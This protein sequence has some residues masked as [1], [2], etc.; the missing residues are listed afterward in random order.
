MKGNW[1]DQALAEERKIVPINLE[2]RTAWKRSERPI[3]WDEALLY[4]DLR[5]LNTCIISA[6]GGGVHAGTIGQHDLQARLPPCRDGQ[7]R[8]IEFGVCA[9][10]NNCAR[11]TIRH[12]WL[13][14]S[15]DWMVQ[16]AI[17]APTHTKN[18]PSLFQGQSG[19]RSHLEAQK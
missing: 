19:Q 5:G 13:N 16:P 8:E 14:F 7:E 9:H 11:T 10:L 18:F 4:L 3:E 1:G 6:K 15:S 2:P 12:I 17:N